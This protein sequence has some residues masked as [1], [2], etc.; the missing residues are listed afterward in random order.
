MG[1]DYYLGRLLTLIDPEDDLFDTLP[2]HWKDKFHPTVRRS[3]EITFGKVLSCHEN[4]HHNPLG[5]QSFLL[6]S[7]VHHSDWLFQEMGKHLGHLFYSITVLK[8]PVLLREL[9]EQ[10]TLEQKETVLIATGIPPCVSHTRA[11][12]K[13]LHL[14]FACTTKMPSTFSKLI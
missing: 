1:G 10:L 12:T 13:L 3:T 8:D 7:I 4:T 9:K 2:S 5:L 11:I 6:A 14:T